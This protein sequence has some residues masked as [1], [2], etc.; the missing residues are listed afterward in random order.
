MGL[1][2]FIIPKLKFSELKFYPILQIKLE[3][4]TLFSLCLS[5]CR[6]SINLSLRPVILSSIPF[7]DRQVEGIVH[8]WHLFWQHFHLTLSDISASDKI[9]QLLPTFRWFIIL[10]KFLQYPYLIVPASRSFLDRFYW[11]LYYLIWVLFFF[12]PPPS[13]LKY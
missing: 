6:I 13:L 5:V 8:I 11:L 1:V 2:Y 12:S 10:I 7:I 3:F 4:F 9:S